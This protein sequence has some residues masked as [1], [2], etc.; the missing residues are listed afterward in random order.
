MTSLYNICCDCG[1]FGFCIKNSGK[2][3][4]PPQAKL[5]PYAYAATHAH[6]D[7]G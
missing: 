5:L 2:L 7:S 1:T 3:P 6:V 4:L